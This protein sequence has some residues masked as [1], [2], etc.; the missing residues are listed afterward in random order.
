MAGVTKTKGTQV[1]YIDDSGSDP[2]VVAIGC[3]TGIGEISEN[4]TETDVTCLTSEVVT[5][6]NNLPDPSE[7][8]LNLLLDIDDSKHKTIIANVQSNVECYFAIGLSNGTDAPTAASEGF[9]IPATR[10]FI[11]FRARFKSVPFE[12]PVNEV[13]RSAVAL[14]RTSA[15]TFKWKTP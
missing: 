3:L 15:L 1:Y 2:A 4:Y 9:T 12:L 5:K 11:T 14:Q 8:V 10:S 13:I 7:I 6:I